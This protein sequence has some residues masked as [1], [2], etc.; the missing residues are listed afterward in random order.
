LFLLVANCRSAISGDWPRFRGPNGSGVSDVAGLPVEFGPNNNVEWK[1]TL[2]PG[3]SSPIVGRNQIFLTAHDG[4]NLVTVCIERNSGKVLW[5]AKITRPRV[6]RLN[7]LNNA[8]SPFPA[9]DGE[10]VYVFFQDYGLIS[11]SGEG[12][13]R[14]R[15][16]LGPF[17]NGNGMAASPIVSLFL[18]DYGHV[19]V[20]KAGRDWEVLAVNDLGEECFATPAIADG[21]LYIRTR[22][23]L[24]CFSKSAGTGN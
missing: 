2:A 9:T 11:Y 7:E 17:R 5:Q 20:V 18:M 21:R 8:A 23:T 14:W 22:N 16:P 1:V 19:A 24:Y 15:L 10:N 4:D 6:G 13:E 3:H 12:H